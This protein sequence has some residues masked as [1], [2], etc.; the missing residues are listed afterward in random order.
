MNTSTTQDWKAQ[1]QARAVVAQQLQAANPHLTP[2]SAG[3]SYAVAAKNIRTELKAAFPA[4]KFS[5]RSKSY[6]MGN[7][8]NVDW[9]DGPTAKQVEEIVG[10]YE[11]GSFD[12]MTDS[13]T[14][15]RSAW[16]DAFGSTKYLFCNRSASDKAIASAVR[17]TNAHLGT[18]VSV[19]DYAQ[20]RTLSMQSSGG[21]DV[22]RD[23]SQQISRQTFAIAQ[24]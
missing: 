16:S 17:R 2:V 13:Y 4:V 20:G 19:D 6:S 12:G 9:T 5:V 18:S 8:I 24:R 21:C 1:Q 10:K 7:S 3:S 15:T 11:G 22:H 14:Y 23:I